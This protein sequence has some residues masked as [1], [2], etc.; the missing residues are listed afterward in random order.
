M[1]LIFA[2][3]DDR[4]GLPLAWVSVMILPLWRQEQGHSGSLVRT[5]RR[6]GVKGSYQQKPKSEE[7]LLS[8][9]YSPSL[10]DGILLDD[11]SG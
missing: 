9:S 6:E 2:V 3:I 5:P 4:N 1:K 8:Y 7:F 10:Q 11:L